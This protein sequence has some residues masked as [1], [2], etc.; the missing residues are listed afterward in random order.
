MNCKKTSNVQKHFG[1]KTELPPP[2]PECENT[3]VLIVQKCRHQNRLPVERLPCPRYIKSDEHIKQMEYGNCKVDHKVRKP[4]IYPTVVKNKEFDRIK[5]A[6]NVQTLE[7]KVE[8]LKKDEEE[9]D[10]IRMESD[11]RKQFFKDIDNERLKR[12]NEADKNKVIDSDISEAKL[13]KAQILEKSFIAR[14]ENEE[15]VKMANRIILNAKCSI[16]RQIQLEEKLEMKKEVIDEDMKCDRSMLDK[17]KNWVSS[18][19]AKEEVAR[20]KAIENS[21]FIKKQLN[22]KYLERCLEQERLQEE[23]KIVAKAAEVRVFLKIFPVFCVYLE[24]TA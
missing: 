7:E 8:S 2:L 10:R 20:E 24:T 11:K 14:F 12:Q 6:E 9:E 16:I 13:E 5:E 19:D 17:T 15:E 23:A 4:R 21:N 3:E 22:E 18:E 1:P